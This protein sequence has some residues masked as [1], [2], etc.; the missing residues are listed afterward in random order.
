[1]REEFFN[2]HNLVTI[3]LK[4]EEKLINEAA[5]TVSFFRIAKPEIKPEISIFFTKFP[6]SP[7]ENVF[8]GEGRYFF[9]KENE[10]TFFFHDLKEKTS[11]KLI[12]YNNRAYYEAY[13]MNTDWFYILLQNALLEKEC[14]L[15]HS[16]AI[17]Y[18]EKGI[19]FPG[20][21]GTGKTIL[22]GELLKGEEISFLGDDFII[23][24]KDKTVYSFPRPLTLYPYHALVFQKAFSQFKLKKISFER[25]LYYLLRNIAR[26]F[27][28]SEI[29]LFFYQFIPKG[30]TSIPPQSIFP[31]EK[32][33]KKAK[34]ETILLL[35]R[36]QGDSFKTE[37]ISLEE[38]KNE[39]IG[40]TYHELSV[41]NIL[42]LMIAPSCFSLF[43]LET[44]LQKPFKIIERIAREIPTKKILIPQKATPKDLINYIL[45]NVLPSV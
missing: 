13:T 44:F 39:T 25:K 45:E 1:M 6:P 37:N 21:G 5:K 41:A 16:G 31:K 18:K 19:L 36:W 28:P 40:I 32:I 43:N 8:V 2:I 4:G 33:G 30:R 23:V 14:T 12:K 27:L 35:S 42:P 22:T 10:N 38:L 26:K 34:I 29:R 9:K 3:S 11:L 7:K 24:S 20:W 15:L 17:N